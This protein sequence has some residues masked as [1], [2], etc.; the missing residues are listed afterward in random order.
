MQQNITTEFEGFVELGK[1][2]EALADF[3]SDKQS[4]DSMNFAIRKALTPVK[5]KA[6]Q[7]A[8]YD[9][10]GEGVHL[11]D[12]I[13]IQTPRKPKKVIKG[14]RAAYGVVSVGTKNRARQKALAAEFGVDEL[15]ISGV[16]LNPKPFLRPALYTNTSN[17]IQLLGLHLGKA[18][19]RRTKKIVKETGGL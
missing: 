5:N 17:S 19:D 6:I 2:L 16:S 3:G 9:E 14:N 18:I 4:F 13:K 1:R 10:E 11:K 15:N 12:T 8:P 7:L